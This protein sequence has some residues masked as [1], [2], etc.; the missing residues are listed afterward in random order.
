[1]NKGAYLVLGCCAVFFCAAS[2]Y[3]QYPNTL[4]KPAGGRFPHDDPSDSVHLYWHG[5]WYD[6]AYYPCMPSQEKARGKHNGAL[7][8]TSVCGYCDPPLDDSLYLYIR[9]SCLNGIDPRN[10]LDTFRLYI[11]RHPYAT[12]YPGEVLDAISSTLAQTSQL[13]HAQK[14]EFIDNY[15]WLVKVQPANMENS[16]Q[17]EVLGTMAD[18]LEQI[19]LNEAAD[20]WWNISILFPDTGSVNLCWRYIKEIRYYQKDIPQ[21]TTPF[22]KL[23]FPLQPLPGGTSGITPVP[24]G[25]V[26]LSLLPN[27]AKESTIAQI[28]TTNTGIYTL[29]LFD[30]L[31]KNVRDMFSEHITFGKKDIN[32]NLSN[33]SSGEYYLR[34]LYPGGVKTVKLVHE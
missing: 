19:D 11:E 16:Y 24:N 5:E 27:P 2:V 17:F 31:G 28:S 6:E 25:F 18:C 10:S 32:L 7:S 9:A 34:L 21:D 29:Q 13:P 14:K 4:I 15:N 1:M 20:M 26:T 22:H 33:L 8:R 23:T 3:G 30:L 12:K